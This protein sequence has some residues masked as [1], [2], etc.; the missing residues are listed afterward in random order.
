MT[1]DR[2]A[3]RRLSA[4]VFGNEKVAEIVLL[5][6]A[7]RGAVLASEI[8]RKTGF[9]HSLVRDVL[10]RLSK[11]PAVRALPKAGNSRGPAYYEPVVDSPVWI[12]L[13]ELARTIETTD[14]LQD[15]DAPL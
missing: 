1:D 12:A 11:T 15:E 13:V 7:E 14:A 8:A 3:T 10:V 6:E 4:L 2:H 9:G 5:L